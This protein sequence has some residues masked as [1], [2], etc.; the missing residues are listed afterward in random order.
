M[1]EALDNID[2]Q[3]A[4]RAAVAAALGFV[5]GWERERQGSPAGDRTFAVVALGAAAF[6]TIAVD[7]FQGSAPQMLGGIVTGIGFLGAGMLMHDGGM[8]RGL[9]SAAALWATAAV[10]MVVGSG[11][12]A[13]GILL[14]PSSFSSWPGSAFPACR[15]SAIASPAPGFHRARRRRPSQRTVRVRS[16]GRDPLDG[17]RFRRASPQAEQLRRREEPIDEASFE[18]RDRASTTGRAAGGYDRRGGREPGPALRSAATPDRSA[19]VDERGDSA[20]PS[21]PGFHGGGGRLR[22]GLRCRPRAR[23]P[24]AGRCTSSIGCPS[25]AGSSSADF[26]ARARPPRP[27]GT[28]RS[29]AAHIVSGHADG[30]G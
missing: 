4:L 11:D 2:L 12:L 29:A 18:R 22:G 5:I 28:G 9:T 8:T 19:A 10:G 16:A 23:S 30:N 3:L 27:D 13:I 25:C 24:R 26:S 15:G 20:V 7:R 1:F 6:T 14:T 17:R 21:R